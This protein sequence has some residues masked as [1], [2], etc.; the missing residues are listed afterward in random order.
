MTGKRGKQLLWLGEPR[1]CRGEYRI[2]LCR[3]IHLFYGPA[4]FYLHII[5][6]FSVDPVLARD[7][8]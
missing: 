5:L 3:N 2:V 7:A 4:T 8:A 6:S 1:K